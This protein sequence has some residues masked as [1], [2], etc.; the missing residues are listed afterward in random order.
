MT[1][2]ISE[3]TRLKGVGP[4]IA[5]KLA[6]IGITQISDLL[7]HLPLRYQDRTHITPIG[8]LVPG[9]DVV[10][11]GEIL[12]SQIRF[13]RRRTL[14]VTVG[15]GSGFL[16]LRFFH[17][18]KGQQSALSSGRWVRCF[19]A[20]RF[21]KA[22]VEMAHPEYQPISEDEPLPLQT[23][24]TPIYPTTEG[25][26][27]Q[28]L[29]Q[30]S[31]QALQLLERGVVIDELLPPS[32]IDRFA[33]P[34]LV[35][36]LREIHQPGPEVSV[37]QLIERSHPAQKRL[38]FEEL[39]A[40]QIA[41]RQLRA[42]AQTNPAVVIEPAPELHGR[43]IQ[44]LPFTLTDA[45]QRVISE[46]ESDLNRDIPMQR[47]IQGDVGSGKTVVAAAAAL[48]TINAGFQCAVMA[49][50]EL[51]ANQHIQSL[52]D[53]LEPLGINTVILT[54]KKGAAERREL[55]RQIAEGEAQLVV[56]THA[57]FQDGV[58]F[59]RLGLSIIDE[60]HRFGVHQRLALLQKGDS[61]QANEARAHQLV[62]TATPIPRTL[63]MTA[64][65]DLDLSIIDELPKG[66]QP[67]KTVVLKEER[68]IEVIERI[69][70]ACSEGRQS[71]WVCPLV[72][73][74]EQLQCQA[75]EL[76][77]EQ[78]QQQ[79]PELKVG[80]IH[81]RMKSE[82]KERVM[83]QFK[84]GLIQLLVA[85]TVIEVGVD[86]PNA[87][88]MV[89]E[90]SERLGLAQLHQLRGRVGRGKDQSHCLLLYKGPLSANGQDRLEVMRESNDGFVIAQRDLEIRGPGEIL[91]TR[92][93][94]IVS[95]R[96]ADIMRDQQWLEQ[97]NP[98]AD[99]FIQ[100]WPENS[101]RLIE[102][103]LGSE[104]ENYKSV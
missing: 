98:L 100:L 103:W 21:T 2:L 8:Q 10:I 32:V 47:L 57:L 71:Y 11:E 1:Q 5:T 99:E 79:L 88:L 56:G 15:D 62:M 38:I 48:Q 43:F 25:L 60:Q 30:L 13:G 24:L 20:V 22:G 46:I 44:Q 83:G 77:Y 90:N 4:A 92:Q 12:T 16:L 87:T 70:A 76:T 82:L 91:G 58:E 45:Q 41:I 81:G 37:E 36:A 95:Y 7:F 68:R 66:R 33:L 39:L 42:Q 65:A 51:L 93:T 86:V 101:A 27:Q 80:L 9:R 50:T 23:T 63:A 18:N 96:I 84:A 104:A 52:R 78:L 97:I 3:I 73:E 53:W 34:P 35:E 49:P 54:G 85:T 28:R 14:V 17:F 55:L 31:Q 29:R 74:S 59:A 61:H 102:R 89:I 64:Y 26:N 75:A 40:H 69:R 67:I 19:G 72:E 94:G 6:R